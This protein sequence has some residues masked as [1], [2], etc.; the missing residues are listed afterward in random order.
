M[1]SLHQCK[2]AFQNRLR[3]GVNRLAAWQITP[4]QVTAIA[5]L[6]C[7]IGGLAIAL[8]P[9]A[10]WPLVCLPGVLLVRMALNAID[11][12]LA[13]EHHLSS[14][15][16]CLLNELGDVV[17]DAALYLPF[18]LV[19]TVAAPGVVMVVVLAIISE[20]VGVLG[21]AVSQQRHYEGPMGKSDRALVF[22]AIA[23]VLGLGVN[24]TSWLNS[25]WAIVIILQ[26]WTILNRAQAALR[27]VE[28]C[29]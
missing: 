19:P 25:V 5:V 3:P 20:M 11:G 10:R 14:N 12:M 24:P 13:R 29:Q 15:L 7:C 6:L 21:L 18:A 9:Q 26:I 17:S 27:E 16:G 1:P 8:F 22:G 2:P 23:L 28:S 4:N